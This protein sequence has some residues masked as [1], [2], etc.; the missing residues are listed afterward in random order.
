MSGSSGN[1]AAVEL[2]RA[3]HRERGIDGARVIAAEHDETIH[4]PRT[5]PITT[6][7][8]MSQAQLASLGHRD[9]CLVTPAQRAA[10]AQADL[11]TRTVPSR[12][13]VRQRPAQRTDDRTEVEILSGTVEVLQGKVEVLEAGM[14]RLLQSRYPHG[15]P[16]ESRTT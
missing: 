5:S 11:T 4:D 14:Q 9:G 12:R 1:L 6:D 2:R 10:D 7:G 16:I 3:D 15:I 8:A 13:R